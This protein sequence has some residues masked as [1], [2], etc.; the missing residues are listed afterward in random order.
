MQFDNVFATTVLAYY[1]FCFQSNCHFARG[2]IAQDFGFSIPMNATV[3]GIVVDAAHKANSSNS[4]TDTVVQLLI[5]G[6][7]SGA[8][9]ALTNYWPLLPQYETYGTPTD[10][11][12][13][14]LTPS[15]INSNLFGVMLQP[16]NKSNA[17]A[18]AYFD[19]VQITVYYTL[20]TGIQS[21]QQSSQS[22]LY[23]ALSQSL[24]HNSGLKYQVRIHDAAGRM[25]YENEISE[26]SQPLHFL[27]P[28]VYTA[29][30]QSSGAN[31]T[32]QFSI[33]H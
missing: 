15:D 14:V 6:T 33:Q 9:Y 1:P 31:S 20:P 12:G 11:W 2:I 13:A 28:G 32:L 3:A 4:I 26:K 29:V 10:L 19:H 30:I 25:V 23:D 17:P 21:W 27:K 22:F 5:N 8:N 7:P 18:Q 24:I 16:L